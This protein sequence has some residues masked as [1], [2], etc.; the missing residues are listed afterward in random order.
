MYV[1]LILWGNMF[2]LA[3]NVT[4]AFNNTSSR[5][6]GDTIRKYIISNSASSNMIFFTCLI[7]KSCRGFKTV[8]P[9]SNV[10]NTKTQSKFSFSAVILIIKDSNLW[11]DS[12]KAIISSPVG[13]Q[14][15]H[16]RMFVKEIKITSCCRILKIEILRDRNSKSLSQLFF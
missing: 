15:P 7:L 2:F 3:Q 4:C 16:K 5:L 8:Q 11:K 1:S 14:T 6:T 10:D 12:P 13:I 9:S